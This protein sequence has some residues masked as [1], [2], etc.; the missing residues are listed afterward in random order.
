MDQR[1]DSHSIWLE[2]VLNKL[3]DNVVGTDVVEEDRE[4]LINDL[5]TIAT[6]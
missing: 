6:G 4:V 2:R 5:W 1:Q 3:V